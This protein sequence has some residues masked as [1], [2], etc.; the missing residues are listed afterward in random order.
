[1]KQARWSETKQFTNYLFQ[2]F[3][4]GDFDLNIDSLRMFG[5]IIA[6]IFLK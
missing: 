6:I 4:Q 3:S 1:M 2:F 5:I